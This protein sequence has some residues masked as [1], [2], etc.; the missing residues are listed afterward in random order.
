MSRRSRIIHVSEV[1]NYQHGTVREIDIELQVGGD[2]LLQSAK[3]AQSAI[4]CSEKQRYEKKRK[5]LRQWKQRTIPRLNRN[6]MAFGE[7]FSEYIYIKN[8]IKLGSAS[9][10]IQWPRW[11]TVPGSARKYQ[12]SSNCSKAERWGTIAPAWFT[13]V[14]IVI[15]SYQP[16]YG[17]FVRHSELMAQAT[18]SLQ[19]HSRWMSCPWAPRQAKLAQRF[20][21]CLKHPTSVR[22][23]KNLIQTMAPGQIQY[24]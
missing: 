19:R 5:Q 24:M 7:S 14:H 10:L 4:P 18:R 8:L 9:S 12:N 6:R 16:K 17:L 11:L 3:I 1:R 2:S 22:V 21:S 13:V 15:F 20:F 23:G